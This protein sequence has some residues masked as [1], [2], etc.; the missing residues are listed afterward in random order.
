M[1]YQLIDWAD[2]VTEYEDR[3]RE[4]QNSDGTVTH[5][6]VEGEVVQQ[7]TEMSATNF[8]HMDAGIQESSALADAL[9]TSVLLMLGHGEYTLDGLIDALRNGSLVAAKAA[10][11]NTARTISIS[12]GASSS[13]ASFDGSNNININVTALDPEKLSAPTPVKKGGTGANEAS[14]ARD[15][16]DVPSREDLLCAVIFKDLQHS[17]EQAVERDHEDRLL[18]V[19]AQLAALT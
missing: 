10:V 3:Y 16:L 8:N 9:Y 12:G 4:I 1:A 17:I 15:N 11:L 7:G 14:A 6:K 13:G 2:Q 19:E 18:T 5:E